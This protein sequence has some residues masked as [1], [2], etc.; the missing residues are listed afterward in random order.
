MATR[1]RTSEGWTGKSKRYSCLPAN[2]GGQAMRNAKTDRQTD[3]QNFSA[4]G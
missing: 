3:R 2:I 1:F 4:S